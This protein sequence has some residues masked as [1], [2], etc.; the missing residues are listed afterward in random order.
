MK[1]FLSL[2]LV[3]VLCLFLVGCG[4]SEKDVV[5]VWSGEYTYNGND[6]A[7]EFELFDDGT[8]VKMIEKNGSFHE[9]EMGVYT[10]RHNFL[11]S[12]VVLN[13]RTDESTT[14]YTYRLGVLHNGGH[15]FYRD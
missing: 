5:G 6:F 11:S 7:V 2:L 13:S 8:Y 1:T 12:E 4:L 10:I 15:D 14:P 3:A 9:L